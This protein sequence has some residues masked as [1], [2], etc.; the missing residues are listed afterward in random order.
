MIFILNNFRVRQNDN[1]YQNRII[2]REMK[3]RTHYVLW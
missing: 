1:D 3:E 2:L